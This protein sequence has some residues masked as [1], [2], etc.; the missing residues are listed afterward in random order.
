MPQTDRAQ[1]C[2]GA[3]YKIN[4]FKPPGVLCDLVFWP[5]STFQSTENPA[6]GPLKEETKGLEDQRVGCLQVGSAGNA[7]DPRQ[8]CGDSSGAQAS[9]LPPLTSDFSEQVTVMRM[10]SKSVQLHRSTYIPSSLPSCRSL[11][12]AYSVLE[13]E[14]GREGAHTKQKHAKPQGCPRLSAASSLPSP[15]IT[16][17]GS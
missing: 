6:A 12:M 4:H 13:G 9:R 15:R 10:L 8:N 2:D 1:V 17:P 11:L 7:G 16:W 14:R 3:E 5:D